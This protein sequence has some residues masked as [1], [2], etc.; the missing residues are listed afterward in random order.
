VGAG[1]QPGDGRAET[2]TASGARL[3]G[4]ADLGGGPVLLPGS[5]CGGGP[6]R[7]IQFF[8]IPNLLQYFL[9]KFNCLD[10]KNAKHYH[11]YVHKFPNLV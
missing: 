8:N 11:P 9:T 5:Y 10:F 2:L 6:T 7:L 3:V 1:R 4:W